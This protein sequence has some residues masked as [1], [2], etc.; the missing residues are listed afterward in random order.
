[1]DVLGGRAR[2]C[3]YGHFAE[4][5]RGCFSGIFEGISQLYDWV[6]EY[7]DGRCGD[8]L[9]WIAFAVAVSRGYEF[10]VVLHI[11]ANYNSILYRVQVARYQAK[12]IPIHH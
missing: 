10:D 3:V 9:D 5:W 4:L 6:C 12:E 1:M 8:F 7:G 11:G 2:E